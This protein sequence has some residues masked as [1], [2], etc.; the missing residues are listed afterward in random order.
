[1]QSYMDEV[2]GV[3]KGHVVAIRG[4]KLK[5]PIDE[6]AGGRVY[7]GKQA[8]ELGLVDKIGT[9][10]DAIEYVANQ[11]HLTEYDVRAV[12]E[13]KNFLEKLMEGSTGGK[14]DDKYVRTAPAAPVNLVDLA[15]PYLQNMDPVRVNTVKLAL[16]RMM[17]I[18]REGAVVMM[19]EIVLPK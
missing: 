9:M 15:L 17:L 5:K 3:F 12:P 10:Q 13:P 2:Y 6:L 4:S 7:T 11:A 14:D 18:Q 19:P 16:A 8:L 1:M